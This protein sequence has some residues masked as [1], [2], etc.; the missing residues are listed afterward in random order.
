MRD[1]SSS[2]VTPTYGRMKSSR[3]RYRLSLTASTV[4]LLSRISGTHQILVAQLI[5]P[6]LE[7]AFGRK[8]LMQFKVDLHVSASN[9]GYKW[10][11]AVHNLGLHSSRLTSLCRSGRLR[12]VGSLCR[13]T[14]ADTIDKDELVALSRNCSMRCQILQVHDVGIKICSSHRS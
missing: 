7:W 2:A 5:V 13:I 3:D 1:S 8:P 12:T 4:R 14:S 10:R 11:P 6:R 9:C